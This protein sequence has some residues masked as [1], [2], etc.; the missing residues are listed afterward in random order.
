MQV[1]AR[2]TT[3]PQGLGIAGSPLVSGLK[4]RLGDV[5]SYAVR[6]MNA[7]PCICTKSN[8]TDPAGMMQD[9]RS[10]S[11]DAESHVSE[12]K[13]AMPRELIGKQI[14]EYVKRCPNAKIIIGGYCEGDSQSWGTFADF[15][16]TRCQSGSWHQRCRIRRQGLFC[17]PLWRSASLPLHCL[18]YHLTG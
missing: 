11:R 9:S 2:G 18:I 17:G 13:S 3:E 4:S 7:W 1:F 14:K 16:S 5:S 10:G 15:I 12:P 6:C 8:P